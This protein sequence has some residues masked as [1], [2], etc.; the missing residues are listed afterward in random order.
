MVVLTRN[1]NTGTPNGTP[2]V[3]DEEVRRF[4]AETINGMINQV[5]NRGPQLNHSRMAKIEFPKFSSDDVKGWFFRIH[6]TNVSWEVYKK[7]ILA[8]FGNVYKDLMSELKNLKYETTAREYEDEFDSLLSRVEVSEEHIVSLFM[9][10]LPT[11]IE[12]GSLVL[13]PEVEG[14][15]CFL[16]IDESVVNNGLMDLQE[17]LISLNA[18]TGTNN[19]KT[20][21]VIGTVGKHVLHILIDCGSTH[22]F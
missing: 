14:E 12:M 8:R 10:G 19:F 22:N 18:L 15:G 4:L 5:M 11:K 2:L 16:E 6:G 1:I 9:G 20:M 21:R 17:P 7:S 13:V 3:L